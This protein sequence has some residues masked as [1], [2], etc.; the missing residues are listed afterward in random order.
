MKLLTTSM[1]IALGLPILAQEPGCGSEPA[2]LTAV[3][4]PTEV[5]GDGRLNAGELDFVDAD[6][7]TQYL[8]WAIDSCPTG[9]CSSGT[10]DLTGWN[11]EITALTE[12]TIPFSLSCTNPTATDFTFGY[13]WKLYQEGMEGVSNTLETRF[14]CHGTST[15]LIPPQITVNRPPASILEGTSA[16]GSLD[17]VDGN[18]GVDTLHS[19]PIACPTGVVCQPESVYLP[20]G[21]PDS[22]MALLEGTISYT[23]TC[24][25]PQTQDVTYTLGFTLED[26]QGNRSNEAVFSFVCKASSGVLESSPRGAQV[27][28]ERATGDGASSVRVEVSGR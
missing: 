17:F 15:E 3:R 10:Y 21:G 11:P 4:F 28:F 25:N 2:T 22:V 7:G 19:R 24:E 16:N 12:G 26:T 8:S 14:V 20:D 18:G 13:D 6:A 1:V 27:A 9:G 5:M 23:L